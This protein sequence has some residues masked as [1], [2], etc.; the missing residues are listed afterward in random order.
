MNKTSIRHITITAERGLFDINLN[1]LWEY[2]D[3][4]WL[5]VKKD[6][7]LIYKQTILG[8]AWIVL[9]PLATTLIYLIVFGNIANLSTDG[10]PKIL[11]Y[12]LGNA[13]WS[14]FSDCIQK[15]GKRSINQN[16]SKNTLK[17][18]HKLFNVFFISFLK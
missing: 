9:R 5:F 13:V 15:T 6:F 8:P 11:F 7:S 14:F 17:R 3:L 12:M 4:I 16:T 10:T 18:L 2:R 1:E